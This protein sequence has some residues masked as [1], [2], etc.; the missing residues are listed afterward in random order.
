MKKIYTII[1][2]F[3]VFAIQVQAQSVAQSE[4]GQIALSVVVPENI[5]D[6]DAAQLSKLKSKVSQIVTKSGL[7][8]SGWNQTF[9][10]YPIFSVYEMEMMETGMQNMFL[11]TVELSMFIKQVSG[12]IVFSSVSRQLKGSGKS[13]SMAIT[14]AISQIPVQD[15]EFV[16]FIAEG[17]EKILSYYKQNCADILKKADAYAKMQQYD[18]A[19]GMLLSIPEGIAALSDCYNKAIAA[20][21]PVY[22]LYSEQRCK[23]L[24][25]EAK[26]F[27]AA[28]KYLGALEKIIQIDP[29][30]S[31]Y[32]EAQSV[33]KEI[34]SKVSIEDKKEWDFMMKRY[35]DNLE[36]TKEQMQI[37]GDRALREQSLD[38][39]RINAIK[40]VAISYYNSQAPV[41][42][43]IIDNSTSPTIIK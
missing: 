26:A 22:N 30:T 41:P 29:T 27:S 37:D 12:N 17:K 11:A 28:Q 24:L 38:K 19:L 4:V 10:I 9:V 1:G 34:E 25:N 15:K 8:A 40:E 18:A 13:K 20:A 2:L 43:T 32:Q 23:A 35:E 14:N 39:E 7:S 42:I 33:I 5:D 21:S 6:L 31:C 3:C 36:L 16:A